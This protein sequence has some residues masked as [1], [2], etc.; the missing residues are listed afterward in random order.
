MPAR[1]GWRSS[2][3]VGLRQ[4][5]YWSLLEAAS[6]DGGWADTHRLWAWLQGLRLDGRAVLGP[7][8]WPTDDGVVS[9]AV[10][11]VGSTLSPPL[12]I[13]VAVVAAAACWCARQCTRLCTYDGECVCSCQRRRKGKAAGRA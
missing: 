6:A 10:L 5:W 12:V 4:H 13:L 11:V 3:L 2:G 9:S 1:T 8:G 7:A